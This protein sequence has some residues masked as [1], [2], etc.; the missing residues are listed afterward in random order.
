MKGRR[1]PPILFAPVRD[2]DPSQDADYA[3]FYSHPDATAYERDYIEGETPEPLP[4]G[5]RVW[6]QRIG[7]A[8][9]AR[10]FVAPD[11]ERN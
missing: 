7:Q 1:T 4:K 9:R 10:G 6:V 5:T 11:V 2:T 3:Y 8:G